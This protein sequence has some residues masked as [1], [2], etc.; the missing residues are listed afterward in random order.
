MFKKNASLGYIVVTAPFV[1]IVGHLL[2]SAEPKKEQLGP[3]LIV[4]VENCDC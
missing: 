4:Y 1:P 3:S 2:M